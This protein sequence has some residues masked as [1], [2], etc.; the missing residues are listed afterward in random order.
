MRRKEYRRRS[1]P[2]E[3]RWWQ[4]LLIAVAVVAQLLMIAGMAAF[5]WLI[6]GSNEAL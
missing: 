5:M 6:V 3:Y 1:R 4:L 2:N